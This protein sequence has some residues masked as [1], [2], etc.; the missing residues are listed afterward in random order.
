MERPNTWLKA[1]RKVVALGQGQRGGRIDQVGVEL[2]SC[3]MSQVALPA[4]VCADGRRM[5]IEVSAQLDQQRQAQALVV[6]AF[7]CTLVGR[8]IELFEQAAQRRAVRQPGKA[9]TVLQ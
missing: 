6:Q 3:F 2:A 1:R 7:Q 4:Y 8:V 9:H 5:V